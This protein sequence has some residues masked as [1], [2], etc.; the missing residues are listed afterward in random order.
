MDDTLIGPLRERE[1]ERERERGEKNKFRKL[2]MMVWKNII[3]FTIK[4]LQINI[5]LIIKIILIFIYY[6]INIYQL[7]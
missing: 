2:Q 1:R 7:Y 6:V 4:I 5:S 3:D